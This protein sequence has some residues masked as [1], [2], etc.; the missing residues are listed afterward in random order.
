MEY[1]VIRTNELSHHGILGQK[2]GVR[3]Y[4]NA[5]GS[6]T[7]A[8]KK[9]YSVGLKKGI[10]ERA[11]IA[12]DKKANPNKY[13]YLSDEQK[14]KYNYEKRLDLEDE[15]AKRAEE[16][17]NND[18]LWEKYAKEYADD[19]YDKHAPK[20]QYDYDELRELHAFEIIDKGRGSIDTSANV[21]S[22]YADHDPR[23]KALV[24]KGEAWFQNVIKNEGK[25]GVG[26]QSLVE[27]VLDDWDERNAQRSKNK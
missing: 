13:G 3:R 16:F 12:Y 24:D 22:Y 6:L 4:Q 27:Q 1:R 21:W 25:T 23:T 26:Y 5:D 10:D 17:Q 19:W 18:K 2:W 9:R 7:E 11:Y 15:I 8:G 14:K 20:D